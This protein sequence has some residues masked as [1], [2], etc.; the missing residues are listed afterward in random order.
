MLI[1]PVQPVANQT[2]QIQLGGQPCTLNL[3]QTMF[4]L[5]MD[6]YVGASPIVLGVICENLNRI[7]RSKY[8]GFVG[9]FIFIDNTGTGA[10]P[11]YYSLNSTFSLAY[12]EASDL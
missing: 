3:Y 2:L 11:I 8:L 5:F 12:L 1:V 9:D 10:D 4:G 7:V 6:V